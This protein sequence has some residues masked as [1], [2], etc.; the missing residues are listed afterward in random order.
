MLVRY[1]CVMYCKIAIE[2]SKESYGIILTSHESAADISP[3]KHLNK[4][5]E[6]N[7]L[8]E[9]VMSYIFLSR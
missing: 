7:F 8:S 1:V 4:T 9:Q 5:C 6:V 2:D 3:I